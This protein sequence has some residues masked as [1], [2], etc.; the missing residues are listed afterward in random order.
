M[1]KLI[2]VLASVVLASTASAG[3]IYNGFEV[4]N[5]ELYS[6]E[7]GTSVPLA[8]QPGTGD[9]YGGAASNQTHLDGMVK[10]RADRNNFND[11]V[12]GAWAKGNSELE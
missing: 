12:Y 6:S 3:S 11:I 5:S 9:S 1:K 4:G 8:V 7:G 2:P 10:S